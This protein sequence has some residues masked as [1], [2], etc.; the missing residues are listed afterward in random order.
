MNFSILR[1]IQRILLILCIGLLASWFFHSL[2]P[3][4]LILLAY[5]G[6]NLVQ[7]VRINHWLLRF[8]NDWEPPESNGAWGDLFNNLYRLLRKES[9]ARDE[10]AQLIKRTEKSMSAL[11]DGVILLDRRQCLETWNQAAAHALG[12]RQASDKRQ[13]FTN[14]VRH[15]RMIEYLRSNDFRLPLSLPAPNDSSKILEYSI[16]RFGAGEYLLII[17]DT[18][19][20]YRLEQMR[21]D[22]VANVSHELKTPLT[23]FKGYLETLLDTVAPEKKAVYKALV[24]MSEQSERMELLINDLLLLA[25]LENTENPQPHACINLKPLLEELVAGLSMLSEE[26]EQSVTLNIPH[27]LH[28][29]GDAMELRSA[30]SNLLLNAVNYTPKQGCI[31]I[32][33]LENEET[34]TLEFK[35]NGPGIATHHLPRLTERFY[36]TDPS[37]VTATGGTGLGLAIVKHVLLRHSSHLLIH[38]TLGVGSRFKCC[39]PAERIQHVPENK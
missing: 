8:P 37:R 18:T 24:Q 2:W 25:Q 19:R 28:V 5:T 38:S 23:V 36:R 39:F 9:L 12:L 10:L 29:L 1:E 34:G 15:P 14:F 33:W 32:N 16:T 21:K 13:P 20:L 6:F 7:L 30:F 27:G 31:E 26:K 22:F 17:R 4:V 35:D 11:R 3:L